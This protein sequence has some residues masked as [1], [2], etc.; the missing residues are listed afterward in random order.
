MKNSL[1]RS[2][3]ED[4]TIRLRVWERTQARILQRA[5]SGATCSVRANVLA[6]DNGLRKTWFFCS[7][8][9]LFLHFFLFLLE[10]NEMVPLRK[11]RCNVYLFLQVPDTSCFPKGCML[12]PRFAQ[13]HRKYKNKKNQPRRSPG[14]R[15]HLILGENI[16][17]GGCMGLLHFCIWTYFLVEWEN[18]ARVRLCRSGCQLTTSSE[19]IL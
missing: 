11:Q 3:S 12:S 2:N 18:R 5:C 19:A 16:G 4:L 17:S 14:L 15:K 8:S 1:G 10:K 9:F 13:K 7:F 6:W